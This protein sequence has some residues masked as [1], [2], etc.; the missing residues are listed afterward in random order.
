V[1]ENP[2]QN[3]RLVLERGLDAGTA[4]EILSIDIADVDV[5]PQHRRRVADRPGEADKRIA[6]AKARRRAGDG[7]RPRAGDAGAG[8]RAEAEVPLALAEAFRS[9]RLG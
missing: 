5:G 3:L 2:D 9:G 4:Y 8:R 7:G 1:L 6:Q